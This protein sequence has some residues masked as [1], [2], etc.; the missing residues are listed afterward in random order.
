MVCIVM[1]YYDR[2]VQL[3]KT[4]L[5]IAESK[6]EDFR[7]II[8]DDGSPDDIILPKVPYRI[9]ILKIRSKTWTNCSPVYNYGFNHALTYN[10]GVIIIQSAECYHV[11][12]VIS[13]A[14]LVKHNEY[15]A[16]G[17]FQLDKETTFAKHDIIELSE[18]NKFKVTHN[19]EGLGQN[20]WW[21]HPVISYIPQY[22][23][24]AITTRNLC[25]INGIDERFANGYAY[26]DG[27]FLNQVKGMKLR[28]SVTAYP[29]VV[30]QWHD[31]LFPDD[32]PD[33][34]EKNK[35]IY[36]K[37]FRNKDFRSKH[38]ITPDLKWRGF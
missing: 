32:T 22:W 14:S 12:D 25:R 21:N 36:L 27:H 10:P 11:G 3:T 9:D 20:A 30:H 35:Q 18:R 4:L 1:A 24:A 2:Q 16:F 28:I 29:F 17:C 23:C 38:L 5:T 34:T 15:I 31:R 33:L 13:Y 19:K 26:E 37:L 8:V 6:H 7:V